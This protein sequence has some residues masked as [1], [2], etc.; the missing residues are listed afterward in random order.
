VA[1]TPIVIEAGTVGIE[2]A[3][4]SESE[5]EVVS[6][7]ARETASET[8]TEAASVTVTEPEAAEI[9]IVR[10]AMNGTE[11]IIE[12]KKTDITLEGKTFRKVH[13]CIWVGILGFDPPQ[14]N[15]FLF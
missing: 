6:Q 14:M 10:R 9:V 7:P 3:I 11:G 15:P 2:A 1:R 12:K 4:Q 8:A 13:G 5:T